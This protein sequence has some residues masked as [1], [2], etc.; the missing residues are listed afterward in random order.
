MGKSKS[1]V[2]IIKILGKP[3]KVTGHAKIHDDGRVGSHRS[4]NQEFKYTL[5]QAEECL[6]DTLLHECIHAF[7]YNLQL[8][9]K[10]DQVHRLTACLIA[11]F[12]ENP[13]FAQWLVA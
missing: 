8:E 12:K 5:D 10:E 1:P 11:L 13:K 3:Y 4:I 9:L 2:Q 6:K 7:D